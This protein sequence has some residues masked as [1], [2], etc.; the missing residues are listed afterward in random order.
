MCGHGPAGQPKLPVQNCLG[1]WAETVNALPVG[2]VALHGAAPWPQCIS[3]LRASVQ[4]DST[5]KSLLYLARCCTA[6]NSSHICPRLQ[7]DVGLSMILA[8]G[9][10]LGMRMDG[11]ACIFLFLV[12][13]CNV[14]LKEAKTHEILFHVSSQLFVCTFS[15]AASRSLLDNQQTRATCQASGSHS[16]PRK[17]HFFLLLMNEEVCGFKAM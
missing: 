2:R 14:T 16:D 15:E 17:I 13:S 9:A 1:L 7:A 12:S 3:L 8:N 5:P 4:G 6:L 10:L 11:C